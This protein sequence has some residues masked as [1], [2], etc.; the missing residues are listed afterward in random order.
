MEDIDRLF[1]SSERYCCCFVISNYSSSSTSSISSSLF[2]F[3]VHNSTVTA[4]KNQT[5]N[6]HN[7]RVSLSFAIVKGQ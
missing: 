4:N 1:I 7:T 6:V 5:L 3:G 2:L